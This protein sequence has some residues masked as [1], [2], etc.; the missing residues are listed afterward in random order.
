VFF[1]EVL[2]GG[3]WDSFTAVMDYEGEK[4]ENK[5]RY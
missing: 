2:F 1:L 4:V 5:R 3:F